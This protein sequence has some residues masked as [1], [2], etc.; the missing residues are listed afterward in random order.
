[1]SS[2]ML[3]VPD[4]LVGE[5]VD[6]ALA[7]MLGLSR[8]RCAEL[9]GEGH[10]LVNGVAAGKSDRLGAMDIIEV[11][12]PEPESKPTP[13]TDMA[14]LY[15]DEDIVVVDKPV[16]V[17]AHTGPGWE[18]PTVLGNLE[19]AGYRIT[20]YGPPERQGIVHRLD[21][22]TSGAMMVAKSELAYT[23][24]KRA[25]KERTIEKVY[26]AVVA[27]HLDP[28]SG[29]IDA[30]IGRHPSREWRMAV[31]DGGKRAVT[32][33]DAR[34]HGGCPAHRGTPGDGTHPPDTRAH[35]RRRAPVCGGHVLRRRP[36]PGG[37]PG[38][39]P[40]VAARRSP[41]IRPPPHGHADERV[42]PLSG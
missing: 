39:H 26:H 29:T 22:G 31:I 8:S 27:G 5:R 32:H 11:T 33:Y 41:R 9:A 7:R 25:F 42:Q 36:D 30:P 16:G 14:I 15:D 20:S 38:A 10:V 12:I 40:P 35:G 37:A 34:A 13:V 6:A 24:M 23:V 28:A 19:A 1:M 4:A 21:V 17:A 18:G 2:R 3:P